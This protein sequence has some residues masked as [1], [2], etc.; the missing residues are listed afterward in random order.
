MSEETARMLEALAV[1]A[2]ELYTLPLDRYR[3]VCAAA[4]AIQQGVESGR[5]PEHM[6]EEWT[7]GR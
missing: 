7:N 5:V 2:V 1:K 6:I 4:A 3:A